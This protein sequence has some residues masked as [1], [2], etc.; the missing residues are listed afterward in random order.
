[1]AAAQ[2]Y[3]C[4]T[5]K[6]LSDYNDFDLMEV[7]LPPRIVDP[8]LKKDMK[9]VGIPVGHVLPGIRIIVGCNLQL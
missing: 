9:Q 1:M 2:Q 3:Y 8:S 7:G 4:L 5:G 6:P